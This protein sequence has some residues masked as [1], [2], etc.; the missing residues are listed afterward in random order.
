MHRAR[1]FLA[2]RA[3]AGSITPGPVR[4]NADGLARP[5]RREPAG[6]FLA[7]LWSGCSARHRLSA[8][9]IS[10]FGAGSIGGDCT[11]VLERSIVESG[12]FVVQAIPTMEPTNRIKLSSRSFIFL[13]G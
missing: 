3:V 9:Q 1:I 5:S 6:S 4:C 12:V 2:F 10:Y 7:P 11:E 13:G 8:E